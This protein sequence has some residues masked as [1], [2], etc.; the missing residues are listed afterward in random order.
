VNEA[1]KRE[2]AEVPILPPPRSRHRRL[3]DVPQNVLGDIATATTWPAEPYAVPLEDES[4][5]MDADLS[6]LPPPP[7]PSM[8]TGVAPTIAMP[9]VID[10]RDDENP[11]STPGTLLAQNVSA[12]FG[13]R[14][15]LDRCSLDMPA[16]QVTAIIG[17]SGCGKSVF[18]RNLNRMHEVIPTAKM[19]GLITL[20][21]V[22]IHDGTLNPTEV[23]LRIG[24]VFQRPNPFP[25]MSI[26]ENVLAGLKLSGG[27]TGN[28]DE[29]VEWAL[30]R[31]GLWT[32]VKDRLGTSGAA[33]SGGQQQRLCIARSLA[34]RPR[35]LLMDEPCSA[36]DPISTRVIE[37]TIC[38]IGQEITIVI[39]THNMQQA[40]R[41]AQQCAF[42]MI[43]EQGSPGRVIEAG[44]THDIF[45]S[46]R[47]QRTGD[48]VS[49]RFG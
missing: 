32:E 22:D 27:K 6:H 17:P 42:F 40:V 29:L 16:G 4:W 10:L 49:G 37:E 8:L 33:L 25:S 35:V 46:P 9:E 31:A 12:W 45:N 20:D 5:A 1:A 19:G 34:V 26:R 41:V 30:R 15:V 18:L 21:G 11:V 14:K 44:P 24:M 48:Y 47:D 39:V 28:A 23:R 3:E 43:E 36:L 13:A 2:A 38:E 7:P